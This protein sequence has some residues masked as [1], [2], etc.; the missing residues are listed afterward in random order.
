MNSYLSKI[1]K[2]FLI[3]YL[4][5]NGIMTFLIALL[6]FGYDIAQ[7]YDIDFLSSLRRT[8]LNS[9]Y[10]SMYFF[11]VW[12]WN[13]LL[14]E[15]YKIITDWYDETHHSKI[16]FMFREHD[17]SLHWLVFVV[18]AVLLVMVFVL[19][20]PSLFQYDMIMLLVFMILRSAKQIYKNRL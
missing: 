15:L 8:F 18:M 3:I 6:A 1:K 14:F 19:P 5:R 11:L 10:T 4:A 13:Y 12:I 7:Y 17:Y 20:L 16:R 2:D 9:I